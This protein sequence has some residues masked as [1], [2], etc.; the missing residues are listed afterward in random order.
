MKQT[1]TLP[2]RKMFG[3]SIGALGDY[4]AYGFIFTFLSFFLTTVAGISPNVS[5]AILSIAIVWDAITDPICGMC[6]DVFRSKNGKRRAFVGASI[7]PLGASIVMLFLNVDLSPDLKNIYYGFIV[8]VF[9]TAYTIWNIPYYSM[10]AVIAQD[11]HTRTKISG[12]RQVTGFIGTFCAGSL[13]TFIV[14]KLTEKGVATDTAWLYM[15]M[16][17]AAIVMITIFIVWRSTY[18]VEPVEERSTT[19]IFG[20]GE[21]WKQIREA[22]SYRPYLIVIIAALCTN[23]YMALFNSSVLYYTTYCLGVTEVKASILFTVQTAVSILLVP[24]LVKA[25]LVFDK[26][27]VYAFCMGFSG[28][29]MILAKMVGIGSLTAAIVY[30]L[31]LSIGPA[32]Y[33]MFIFNFLYDVADAEEVNSHKRKDGIIMSYYSFLLKLGGAVASLLF[34]LLLDGS[35]FIGDAAQQTDKALGTIESLF[36]IL[37]G[38]FMLIAGL[39]L[40]LSPLTQKRME[41]IRSGRA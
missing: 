9:W 5:G 2:L 14:G 7:V 19:K 26:K 28:A 37:P 20:V 31:L 23:V 24:F 32:A 33:W 8:L 3:Y 17:I 11:D 4:A 10:G 39:V 40:L 38:I 30:M 25:A 13:S 18:G 22:M 41:A 6:M 21:L 12:F 27:Y 34:G 36:T 1:E 35:G 15:A 29:V 16:I